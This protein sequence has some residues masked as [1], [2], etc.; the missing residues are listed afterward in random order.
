MKNYGTTPK[1]SSPAPAVSNQRWNELVDR[2]PWKEI[3]DYNS[4]DFP[5]N[6]N[7]AIERIKTNIAYFRK[8]YAV[9]VFMVVF[10]SLLSHPFTVI[11]FMILVAA[12]NV[13]Y[14][15]REEPLVVLNRTIEDW[16]VLLFLGTLTILM[17]FLSDA[18]V[19]ILISLAIGLMLVL[20][21]AAIMNNENLTVDQEVAGSAPFLA[22]TPPPGSST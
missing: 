13:L 1:T 16:C 14:F 15:V 3:F 11:V 18:T 2:R 4:I 9:I 10:L 7:D 12:W 6:L 22:R 19:N 17:L 21:H 5:R 20:I 8:N